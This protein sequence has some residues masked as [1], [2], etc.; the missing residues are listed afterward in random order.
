MSNKLK[1]ILV[2]IMVF[3]MLILIPGEKKLKGSTSIG[4]MKISTKDGLF[5]LCPEM[6][7]PNCSCIIENEE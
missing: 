7:E 4:G 3:T 2:L 6:F 1:L 5:C